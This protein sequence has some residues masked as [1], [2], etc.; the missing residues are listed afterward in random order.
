MFSIGATRGI[1]SAHGNPRRHHRPPNPISP[2]L[3]RHVRRV[4]QRGKA[5]GA[6][7]KQRLNRL[8]SSQGPIPLPHALGKVQRAHEGWPA[9]T[10]IGRSP[11]R[12]PL[13]RLDATPPT[14]NGLSDAEILS[15]SR[16]SGAD[17]LM[18]CA[19]DAGLAA[20]QAWDG[21]V[22]RDRDRTP[23]NVVVTVR[24]MRRST[25][26]ESR[27]ATAPVSTT[28]LPSV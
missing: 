17:L 4:E 6:P 23:A 14:L 18:R 7:G 15:P 25:G 10:A 11:T 22:Q 1:P 26:W 13:G 21:A 20:A 28:G 8:A 2:P 19:Q 27:C 9:D 3:R 5:G 24:L 16:R 12:G